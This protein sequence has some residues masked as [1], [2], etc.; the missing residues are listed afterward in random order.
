V[1]NRPVPSDAPREPYDL[2]TERADYPARNG[3]PNRSIVICSHPRSGSTLLGEAIHAAGG[4]GCPLEYLHRGFRPSFA[5]RW[6]AGDLPSYVRALH[7]FRTDPSGVLSIKI[8]WRDIEEVAAEAGFGEPSRLEL[9]QTILPNPTF[10]YLTRQDRVR[11]AVSAYVAA[12]TSV[13]RSFSPGDNDARTR[14][15]EYQYDAILRQLAAADYGNARWREFFAANGIEPYRIEFES[16]ASACQPTVG[17]LLRYL[18][19][20]G[21]P[22]PP[23]LL[24]QATALSE[25]FVRRFLHDHDAA[26]VATGHQSCR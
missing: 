25:T 24:R 4:L 12:E 20:S 6:N 8:F 23:R 19:H 17:A 16:L 7:R 5:R 22:P 10:V 1:T 11:Q 15:V 9:L 14:S 2:A 18:G 26:A 3:P 21:A 13:F